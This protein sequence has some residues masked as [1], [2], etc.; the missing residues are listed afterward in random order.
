MLARWFTRAVRLVIPLCLVSGALMASSP[1]ARATDNVP[2]WSRWYNPRVGLD[3]QYCPDWSPN[4]WIPVFPSKDYYSQ[5]PVGQIYAPGNDWYH[6]EGPGI[7]HSVGDLWNTW[8]AYTMADNGQ[9]GWVNEVY[10]Q[11]GANGEPDATL[12]RC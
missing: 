1:T 7:T 9:W 8:W 10:F 3:V 12:V 4:G 11:G 5:Q 2:C 6:C